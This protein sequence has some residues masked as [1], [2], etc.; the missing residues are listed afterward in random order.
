MSVLIACEFSGT[1]RDAFVRRGIPA[2]SCDLI[3]SLTS[4]EHYVGSV[5]DLIDEP[6]DLVIAHPPCTYLSNAG[7]SALL[8]D[9]SRWQPMFDAADFFKA[10]FTFNSPRICVENPVQHAIGREYHGMGRPTQYISPEQYG[11][12]FRKKTGLWLRNLP[13]LRST[14]DVSPLLPYVGVS[15]YR[16]GNGRNP[17]RHLSRQQWR[18]LTASGIADAMAS[19]WGPLL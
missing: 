8:W 15:Q 3:P 9:D 5:L 12:L 4:G 18:S 19:Q 14:V 11:H 17:A 7:S 10:M 13:E 1:I 2:M 6:F 16:V